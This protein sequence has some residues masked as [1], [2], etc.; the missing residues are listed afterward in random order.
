MENWFFNVGTGSY[1][2]NGYD[3]GESELL[4]FGFGGRAVPEL[5]PWKADDIFDSAWGPD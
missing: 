1:R 5:K 3:D 4:T 2:E